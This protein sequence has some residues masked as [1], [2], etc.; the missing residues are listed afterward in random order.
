MNNFSMNIYGSYKNRDNKLKRLGFKSYSEYLKS[1]LWKSIRNQVLKQ[2]KYKCCI[3]GNKANQVHHRTYCI[4]GLAGTNLQSLRAICSS[5]HHLAEFDEN[6]QKRRLK[7]VNKLIPTKVKRKKCSNCHLWAKKNS[8]LCGKCKRQNINNKLSD[9]KNKK[10]IDNQKTKAYSISQKNKAD[11]FG[12]PTQ[13]QVKVL[14]RFGLTAS[15]KRDAKNK[16]SDLKA[17]NWCNVETKILP[18]SE[19]KISKEEKNRQEQTNFWAE[20]WKTH[21]EE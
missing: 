15:S 7:E 1:D 9:K 16:I 20:Y 8:E 10:T 11:W 2:E 5:C 6:G 4:T 19:I 18:K 3:C 21:S 13:E 17:N 14:N 12:P